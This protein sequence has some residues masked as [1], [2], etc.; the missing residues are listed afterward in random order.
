MMR[1]FSTEKLQEIFS[2]PRLN[3]AGIARMAELSTGSILKLKR[4]S[5]PSANTLV[6]LADVLGKPLDYFFEEK[7]ICSNNPPIERAS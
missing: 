5:V 4:G 7:N 1:V 3:L 6:A 2:D